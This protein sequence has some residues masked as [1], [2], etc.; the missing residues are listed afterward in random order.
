MALLIILITCFVI[1]LPTFQPCQTPDDSVAASCLG[2]IMIE[3]FFAIHKDD[4]LRRLSQTTRN[5]EECWVS[6]ALKK[7][8]RFQDY[9]VRL[10]IC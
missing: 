5:P 7:T 10:G 2:R 1:I 9:T 3:G 6:K 4:V 8:I